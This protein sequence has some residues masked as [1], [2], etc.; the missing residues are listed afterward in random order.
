MSAEQQQ[1]RMTYEEALAAAPVGFIYVCKTVRNNL[2]PAMME[3]IALGTPEAAVGTRVVYREEVVN[4]LKSKIA[5]LEDQLRNH[6]IALANRQTELDAERSSKFTEAGWFL[7]K[8]MVTD[9]VGISLD[10]LIKKAKQTSIV[11]VVVSPGQPYEIVYEADW[12]KYLRKVEPAPIKDGQTWIV[13]LGSAVAR[14]NKPHV[15]DFKGWQ[16]QEEIMKRLMTRLG[17]PN[18]TSLA[19]AFKQFANELYFGHMP[20]LDAVQKAAGTDAS[21]LWAAQRVRVEKSPKDASD[22]VQYEEMLDNVLDYYVGEE[23]FRLSPVYMERLKDQIKQYYLREW[24]TQ[25]SSP[26]AVSADRINTGS[27]ISTPEVVCTNSPSCCTR[28]RPLS[29]Q[30]NCRLKPSIVNAAPEQVKV[31]T[32]LGVPDVSSVKEFTCAECPNQA[33]LEGCCGRNTKVYGVPLASPLSS[34][35]PALVKSLH[36]AADAMGASMRQPVKP[37]Y[38]VAALTDLT[39]IQKAVVMGLVGT[40]QQQEEAREFLTQH[41][42]LVNDYPVTM[43]TAM[44]RQ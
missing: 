25:H 19:E 11:N 42:Q 40:P 12:V 35:D 6:E 23:A 32:D 14:F 29:E 33:V 30:G 20:L 24:D 4:A 9:N 44:Q 16:D 7:P 38:S 3:H 28:N 18:S 43:S 1:A 31:H 2:E 27:P 10:H 34:D 17:Q 36:G 39:T 22:R 13:K 41:I 5:E 26:Y 37:V 21:G 8:E 15:V